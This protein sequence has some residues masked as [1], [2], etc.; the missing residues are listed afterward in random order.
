[1]KEI[2]WDRIGNLLNGIADKEVSEYPLHWA[3]I[4]YVFNH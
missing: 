1:M 2:L 4:E 3:L